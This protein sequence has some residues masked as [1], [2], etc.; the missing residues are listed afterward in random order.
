VN[1]A[2]EFIILTAARTSEARYM[3]V[4]EVDFAERLLIIPAERIDHSGRT[5]HELMKTEDDPEGTAFEVPLSDPRYCIDWR[6]L[7][8][9]R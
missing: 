7:S 9:R 3:R 2:A 4:G 5:R 8:A 6:K 1:Q